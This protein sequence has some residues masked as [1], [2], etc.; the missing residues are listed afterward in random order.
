MEE[1]NLATIIEAIARRHPTREAIVWGDRR[2][3]F[4]QL[5]DR[6]GR[7]AN[8]LLSRGL[9][10][11][12]E[13]SALEPWQSGQHHLA[14]YLHN[15]NEYLEGMV[16]AY[17]ARVAPF[18]VNYRYVEE[19]LRYLLDDAGARAIIFHSSFAPTLA[20]V[21]DELPELQVLLQVPDESG[22]DLLPGAEW[23]TM[24]RAPASLSR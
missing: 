23:Y 15:G 1:F 22:H 19:E 20:A 4:G 7:L 14:L 11:R 8:H 10:I 2:I 13:R 9:G 24:A 17:K 6:T 16:G 5:A 3:T 18:N 21:R 12:S